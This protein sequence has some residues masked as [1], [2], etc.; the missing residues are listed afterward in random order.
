MAH[1]KVLVAVSQKMQLLQFAV[2]DFF[3]Y[4]YIYCNLVAPELEK[5][6]KTRPDATSL[7]GGPTCRTLGYLQTA[8]ERGL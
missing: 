2:I 4:Q 5:I 3:D 1:L 6:I 8:A 7:R